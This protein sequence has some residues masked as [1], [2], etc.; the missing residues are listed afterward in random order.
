MKVINKAPE[1][2]AKKST[3]Y[4]PG[5]THGIA[6]RIIVELLEEMDLIK[7]CHMCGQFGLFSSRL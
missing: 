3:S 6:H 4:C 1:A 2:F 7:K 5:C